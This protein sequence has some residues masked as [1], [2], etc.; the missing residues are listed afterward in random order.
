MEKQ[1][2]LDYVSKTPEN[3]NVNVLGGM[4]DELASGGGGGGSGSVEPF[5]FVV[6]IKGLDPQSGEPI[7]EETSTT[8][9]DLMS[10]VADG[11][12]IY[13]H[14]IA[15]LELASLLNNEVETMSHLIA[16]AHVYNSETQEHYYHAQFGGMMFMA[17]S[18]SVTLVSQ[19]SGGGGGGGGDITPT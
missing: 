7:I 14:F 18:P 8:Y 13:C 2:I 9:N 4:L 1:D 6:E 10:M 11:R 19:A 16:V 12:P 15:P 17:T 3:V 5:F